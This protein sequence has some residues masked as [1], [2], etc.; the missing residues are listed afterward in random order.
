MRI[1]IA[2]SIATVSSESLS[3]L[4]LN[5]WSTWTF[6]ITQGDGDGDSDGDGD[7]S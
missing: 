4:S 5:M 2:F 1:P 7:V 6:E 3:G